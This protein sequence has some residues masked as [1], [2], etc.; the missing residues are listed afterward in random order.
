MEQKFGMC[1]PGQSLELTWPKV[2]VYGYFSL[3]FP[4]IKGIYSLCVCASLSLNFMHSCCPYEPRA[5]GAKES[6]GVDE[7]N[8]CVPLSEHPQNFPH[9]ERPEEKSE[10]EA[11]IKGT[12]YVYSSPFTK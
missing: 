12:F 1:Y 10:L 4:D 3:L 6:I 2:T 11:G 5:V 9:R 8:D 7:D